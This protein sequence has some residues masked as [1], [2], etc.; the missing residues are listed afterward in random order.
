LQDTIENGGKKCRRFFMRNDP[1]QD[2]LIGC[3]LKLRITTQTMIVTYLEVVL[4]QNIALQT[5]MIGIDV[6][7]RRQIASVQLIKALGDGW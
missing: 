2:K 6:R 3:L 7:A 1:A 4:A 5:E